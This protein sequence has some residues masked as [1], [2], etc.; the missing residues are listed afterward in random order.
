M[1]GADDG[2]VVRHAGRVGQKLR[3]PGAGFAVLREL[4]DRGRDGEAGLAARHGGQALPVTNGFG[5]VLIEIEQL[6]HF[7]LVIESLHLRGRTHQVEVDAAFGLGR[8][9]GQAGESA[10]GFGGARF[11]RQERRE[12]QGA[13]ALR[14]AREE[15]AAGLL[16]SHFAGQAVER[17]A[18]GGRGAVRFTVEAPGLAAVV[19]VI[20]RQQDGARR[21][22]LLSTSSR[23]SN[24]LASMVRAA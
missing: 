7:R 5:E 18:S 22:H 2:D 12:G 21:G 15:A 3:N 9:M 4:K 20:V 19:P 13:D 1:H 6:L 10:N 23:F 24:S 16:D 8:E 14:G 11:R 17:V